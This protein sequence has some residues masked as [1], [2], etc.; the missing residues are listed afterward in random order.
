M[1]ERYSTTFVRRGH[2]VELSGEV[3]SS[4]I[5]RHPG[6]SALTNPSASEIPLFHQLLVLELDSRSL[7]RMFL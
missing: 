6:R 7:I 5:N 2:W 1:G 3:C 4:G